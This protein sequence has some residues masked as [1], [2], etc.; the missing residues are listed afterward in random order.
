[1]LTV[2]GCSRV[3]HRAVATTKVRSRIA[4]AA[5]AFASRTAPLLASYEHT[6]DGA[7][8]ELLPKH[9][10]GGFGR[11]NFIR[12]HAGERAMTDVYDVHGKLGEGGCGSVF[13]G[14]HKRT[15]ETVAIKRVAKRSVADLDSMRAEVAFLK[16]T[17]H[18]NIVRLYETF[19]CEDNLYLIMEKCSGGELWQHILRAH[20][21]G[22]GF[23]EPEL[24]VAAQQML[25][26]LAY[27]HAHNI[28]HRDVKPENFLYA[29]GGA[30]APL[31]LV[32]FGVS[33][34][35]SSI[36]P[37][38]RFLTRTAGTDGYIAPEV[39]LSR[40]YGS[41]ADMFSLG[42]VMHAAVVGIPPAW[43][44]GTQAY[45][46]PG[47]I[48]WRK[49]SKPAQAFLSRLVDPDP[50]ARPAAVEALQDPWITES[51]SAASASTLL[52]E[53]Y[54]ARMRRFGK[55]S[56]FQKCMCASMVAFG[57][58]HSPEMEHIK[59]IFLDADK[60]CSGEVSVDELS[61]LLGGD[62]NKDDLKLLSRLDTSRNGV[63][64]YSEWL[65]AAAD[66]ALFRD[67]EGVLRAFEALDRD[68]DGHITV[69][70]MERALPGV[71]KYGE[72][73]AQIQSCDAD[74]DGTIDFEEFMELLRQVPA[75]ASSDI[76]E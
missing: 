58:F 56:K 76:D 27:C 43:N 61:A 50:M 7:E 14:Q 1:M 47:R 45:H 34:V 52:S 51:S 49:L 72:L 8:T 16:A 32:D 63:V 33:G 38:E 57:L 11:S 15:K 3:A 75:G 28:V 44:S 22:V 13:T 46:F 62:A 18:P 24:V 5:A 69:A 21:V 30:G 6:G 19:E 10:D 35:V 55:M 41:A 73:A 40:P 48:R 71:F 37:G 42:A 74:A 31:K 25:K 4:A 36:L 60:D 53:D 29:S 20:D 39:L 70:E 65:A 23:G 54:V 26:A 2:R 9:G 64:A 59:N 12:D 68:G 67:R 17:D 66:D